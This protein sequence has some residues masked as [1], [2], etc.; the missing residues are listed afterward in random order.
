MKQIIYQMLPRLWGAYGAGGNGRFADIDGPSL[1]HVRS[2]GAGWIW[3]TGVI[4]HATKTADR[5]CNPSHPQ[6]VKGEA[7]SPYSIT[8]Y[9]DVNPYLATD[10]AHRMEEFEDLIRRTHEAGL[11]VI[12]DFVPNHVA[13]DYGRFGDA[14][15]GSRTLGQD[16]DTTEHWT[17]ENDFFYYPGIPL[18]LPNEEAFLDEV[19]SLLA[20]EYGRRYAILPQWLV[21]YAREGGDLTRYGELLVPFHENPAKATGNNYSP[22]PGISDWYE[23]VKINYCDFPTATWEKMR[24][25]LRFWALKGV[26]GFRCDM[27]ELVPP[28][29]FAWLIPALKQDFPELVFIA[30]VYQKSLYSKYIHEVGFDLLYDKSG[31]YDVLRAVVGKNVSSDGTPIERWQS[32]QQ[33]TGNWQLLGDLQPRM[34]NFLE[35]HDEQR[36]ASPYFAGSPTQGFAALAVSL[37]LNTAPFMLYFGQECGERGMDDE[38]FSGINGRTTIF[39]WWQVDSLQRLYLDIHRPEGAD[40]PLLRRYR[41]LLTLATEEKS[42][43]L[44]RTYDL[45]YCNLDTEGFDRDRHFVFLRS[46]AEKCFLVGVNFSGGEA[47]MRIRI[48]VD[49]CQYLGIPESKA[50]EVPLHMA[51]FD[52][53]IFVL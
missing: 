30:E 26:D 12:I 39:D 22:Q 8:D 5:G 18:R 52:Y 34:L 40:S 16:D 2:L 25:I 7:G 46:D 11:K 17:A 49:A 15:D 51:A 41:E 24:R 53:S 48:P 4:R 14:P 20:G 33:I 44:G 9:Y 23:T 29:F 28:A 35:N 38:P 42:F 3:Y 50:G 1:R 19:R 6:F 36:L 43:S 32:A 27:V 47:S 21:A 45:C 31:L 37:L 10:P 13:R